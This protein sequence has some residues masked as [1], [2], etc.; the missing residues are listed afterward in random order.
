[1]DVFWRE[2]PLAALLPEIAVLLAWAAF[3][4]WLARRVARRWESV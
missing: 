4:F 1:L 2:A 3:F